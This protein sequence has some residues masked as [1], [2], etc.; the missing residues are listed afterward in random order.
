MPEP[1]SFVTGYA[2]DQ[3][4]T[5]AVELHRLGLLTKV[6]LAALAGHCM[7]Y[8]RWRIAEEKIAQIAARDP[9][10]LGLL[11]DGAINPLISISQ[12]AAL[13]ML[14]FGSELG[15]SPVSRCR[16]GTPA[17]PKMKSKFEGLLAG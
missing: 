6:D 13:E 17:Q 5:V 2:A 1:P 9:L 15:L 3:W 10:T 11:I 7:A 8:A 14:R 16:L 4:W 12:K